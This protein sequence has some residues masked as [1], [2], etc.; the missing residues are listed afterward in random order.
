MVFCTDG[1]GCQ[2]LC[3]LTR[4]ITRV[5]AYNVHGHYRKRN[6]GPL[7]LAKCRPRG[8]VCGSTHRM[9]DCHYNENPQKLVQ[10]MGWDGTR[11]G[12][13]EAEMPTSAGDVLVD[14]R[15][16][17][18]AVD[19]SNCPKHQLLLLEAMLCSEALVSVGATES[20][21]DEVS[22][23]C[24]C[25]AVSQ[26]HGTELRP[27]RATTASRVDGRLQILGRESA[28]QVLINS[29]RQSWKAATRGSPHAIGNLTGMDRRLVKPPPSSSMPL[30]PAGL[31]STKATGLLSLLIS[32]PIGLSDTL[33]WLLVGA[34]ALCSV[35]HLRK[36]SHLRGPQPLSARNGPR[37]GMCRANV[38]SHRDECWL[39]GTRLYPPVERCAIWLQL[40]GCFDRPSSTQR[41]TEAGQMLWQLLSAQARR[42]H[43]QQISQLVQG[44]LQSIT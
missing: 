14:G 30:P 18:Q 16:Q 40:G 20:R 43:S 36:S 37:A 7:V 15:S 5:F 19:D 9:R 41:R 39:C 1:A 24:C 44:R 22:S 38:G 26:H 13:R 31:L 12:M 28:T 32:G 33:P 27:S 23:R 42:K 35:N 3:N 11:K 21:E 25:P 2:Y 17:F 8:N 6:S 4:C 34:L 10:G 29:D